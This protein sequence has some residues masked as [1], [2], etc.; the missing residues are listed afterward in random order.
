[1]E[2]L[3]TP[4]IMTIITN[5]IELYYTTPDTQEAAKNICLRLMKA[6]RAVTKEWQTIPEPNEKDLS[7]YHD[8]YKKFV[9]FDESTKAKYLEK[10][11]QYF[12]ASLLYR[13]LLVS[14]FCQ[15]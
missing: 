3:E 15:I 1:M 10:P 13:T 4:N 6:T 9:E 2:P 14:F 7:S 5:F 12:G 11:I 8:L